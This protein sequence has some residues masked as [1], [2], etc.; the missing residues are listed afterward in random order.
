MKTIRRSF[1][2][3]SAAIL[4]T[5]LAGSLLAVIGIPADPA[6][7]AHPVTGVTLVDTPSD[8]CG[9]VTQPTDPKGNVPLHTQHTV[10]CRTSGAL[11]GTARLHLSI[12]FTMTRGSTARAFTGSGD[13]TYSPTWR[14]QQVSTDLGVTTVSREVQ[15][16]VGCSGDG[17]VQASVTHGSGS[18]AT[19]HTV[20]V[21][22][23]C[24][25]PDVGITS[26]REVDDH[27]LTWFG[28]FDVSPDSA[29]CTA[30]RLSGPPTEMLTSGPVAA[31]DAD[32][33]PPTEERQVFALVADE[34]TGTLRVR[35]TCSADGHDDAVR[36]E[37][38]S[39]GHQTP[40]IISGLSTTGTAEPGATYTDPSGFSTA[41]STATCS[42][43]HR[44]RVGTVSLGSGKQFTAT[45]GVAGPV[46]AAIRCSAPGRRSA[47]TAVGVQFA[48]TSISIE[49]L[50]AAATHEA[51][52]DYTDTF[53]TRPGGATCSGRRT[54]SVG[55]F[56]VSAKT[57]TVTGSAGQTVTGTVTCSFGSLDDA[58][59]N[60]SI[61]FTGR[62]TVAINNDLSATGTGTQGVAYTDTFTTAPGDASCSG[63]ISASDASSGS[64]AVSGKTLTV[65][66][67]TEG[68]IT[69][70]VTCSKQ[71]LTAAQQRVTVTFAGR[72]V[73]IS[74]LSGTVSGPAA[75][76]PYT[77]DFT[78]T[79]AAATCRGSLV[80]ASGT[81]AVS[82]KTLTVTS[83]QAGNVTGDVICTAAGYSEGRFTV[84]VAFGAD[85]N[86][87]VYEPPGFEFLGGKGISDFTSVV[88]GGNRDGATATATSLCYSEGGDSLEPCGAF[89]Y[90]R[91]PTVN[92]ANWNGDCTV[93]R[94]TGPSSI[95][96][97]LH[98]KFRPLD[99]FSNT[100]YQIRYDRTATATAD[101][102]AVFRVTCGSGAAQGRFDVTVYAVA[103]DEPTQVLIFGLVK[104]GTEEA[105]TDYTD[106]FTTFPTGAS[107]SVSGVS[108]GSMSVSGT[109]TKT[110]TASRGTGGDV[111]G[112]ITCSSGTLDDQARSVTVTFTSDDT[113][114][115]FDSRTATV[116]GS[117][118]ISDDIT[119]TPST[120]T[121]SAARTGG[122]LSVAPVVTGTGTTRTVTASS[123]TAG[124]LA[125]RVTCGTATAQATF[126]WANPGGRANSITPADLDRN[127]EPGDRLTANFTVAPNA[128]CT[129]A[130][131][132][133][134]LTG[135]SIAYREATAGD[136]TSGFVFQK[137]LWA[138]SN[139]EGHRTANL[140][141][142]DHTVEVTFSWGAPPPSIG[143]FPGREGIAGDTLHSVYTV[144]PPT[145]C[146]SARTGGTAPAA[147]VTVRDLA[148]VNGGY[149]PYVAVESDAAGTV[150]VTLTCGTDTETA[151]FTFTAAATAQG[152][153]ITSPPGNRTGDAG[154]ALVSFFTVA[155]PVN[156]TAVRSGGDAPAEGVTVAVRAYSNG[157]LSTYVEVTSDG[158][159]D[160]DVTLTCGTADPAEAIFTF[161]AAP[162]EAAVTVT[163][164]ESV[165]AELTGGVGRAVSTYVVSPFSADCTATATGGTLMGRAN[166]PDDDGVQVLRLAYI[167]GVI[168][169][170]VEIVS[171]HAGN[172][173]VGVDCT[174]DGEPDATA[175][176]R[177]TSTG[178]ATAVVSGYD[179]TSHSAP[180]VNGVGRIQATYTVSP[181]ISDCSVT[182]SPPAVNSDA[183]DS[184]DIA[185]L[186]VAGS[187]AEGVQVLR[188]AHI[189]GVIQP[190][191]EV[192][193]R[194]VGGVDVTVTCGG[195]SAT[196]AFVFTAGI[197][198]RTSIS[199]FVSRR[200]RWTPG[201]PNGQITYTVSPYRGDCTTEV[202]GGTLAVLEDHDDD[203]DTPERWVLSAGTYVRQLS[204]I[205]GVIQPYVEVQAAVP[206]T[207]ADPATLTVRVHCGTEHAVATFS[208]EAD[209]GAVSGFV[210]QS[211][212][213]GRTLQAV[214]TTT[215]RELAISCT[216][217][218]ATQDSGDNPVELVDNLTDRN[219]ITTAT[220]TLAQ[221]RAV[222]L[223]NGAYVWHYV[224]VTSDTAGTA[225]VTL[226]CGTATPVEATFTWA[227]PG[228]PEAGDAP[229]LL[230]LVDRVGFLDTAADDNI[231]WLFD[232]FN[233]PDD[234]DCTAETN[235]DLYTLQLHR[236][237]TAFDLLEGP[238]RNAVLLAFLTQD[239]FDQPPEFQN[240]LP[241]DRQANER[242]LI[243]A[244]TRH[245]EAAI[246]VTCGE[247]TRTVRWGARRT[248]GETA[249][250]R[251]VLITACADDAENTDLCLPS[252]HRG[253][254]DPSTGT[255]TLTET[256]TVSPS[257]ATCTFTGGT[258]HTS[259]ETLTPATGAEARTLSV[260]FAIPA[261][262]RF[263]ISCSAEN[264]R[265]AQ[266]EVVITALSGTRTLV[267]PPP[268]PCLAGNVQNLV[269]GALSVRGVPCVVNLVVGV[270]EVVWYSVLP[271]DAACVWT[272]DGSESARMW[273]IPENVRLAYSPSGQARYLRATALALGYWN[274]NGRCTATVIDDL[275]IAGTQ[276]YTVTMMVRAV[277]ATD[278]SIDL[279]SFGGFTGDAHEFSW[280]DAVNRLADCFDPSIDERVRYEAAYRSY[281]SLLRDVGVKF[282]YW[283]WDSFQAALNTLRETDRRPDNGGPLPP[284]YNVADGGDLAVSDIE[285]HYREVSEAQDR[286]LDMT[287]GEGTLSGWV[288]W[289]PIVGGALSQT[290]IISNTFE[291]IKRLP[292]GFACS[293]WRLIVP[294]AS[295]IVNV[296][297]WSLGHRGDGCEDGQ[298][299]I[300]ACDQGGLLTW[301]VEAVNRAADPRLHKG[302]S[303]TTDETEWSCHGP[304]IG[305]IRVVTGYTY[306]D[307]NGDGD[308]DDEGER[309]EI[310]STVGIGSALAWALEVGA[311][312]GSPGDERVS[313]VSLMSGTAGDGSAGV[314]LNANG[315]PARPILNDE[316]MIVEYEVENA[317]GTVHRVK[318]WGR[319]PAADGQA[320]SVLMSDTFGGHWFSTCP[321][322]HADDDH[323]G[324]AGVW[325]RL[326]GLAA[327]SAIMHAL[328][329]LA[330]ALLLYRSVRLL[331]REIGRDSSRG[332][333]TP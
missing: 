50:S 47:D 95:T 148:Y 305:S 212:V 136:E 48:P 137:Y 19:T 294:D 276:T 57:L 124:T 302:P 317:D 307:R 53:T 156:C 242:L 333:G 230:T 93:T 10:N 197:G 233:P 207:P 127:G 182:P 227:P 87:G 2:R 65:T 184:N 296:L 1:A 84:A 238:D 27:P 62:T 18:G 39:F 69:G 327:F 273:S 44:G 34:A 237:A 70:T 110:L 319:V 112:T 310:V 290:Q 141:C 172:I 266:S 200:F 151:T 160:V 321:S 323:S 275:G 118:P 293:T 259:M 29:A 178:T 322:L 162:S 243:A 312:G 318:A 241:S 285:R 43:I 157:I 123:S 122:T 78:T 158:A 199:G 88:V 226:T 66:R 128:S 244:F 280:W 42:I 150:E 224:S 304:D 13:V 271:S 222:T 14:R 59:Q 113:I 279:P 315:T 203:P 73:V 316:G 204:H 32:P 40:V 52:T 101:G 193:S 183:D 330:M 261:S 309:S 106:E 149:H 214:F 131:T 81:F 142:G 30:A 297:T 119:V 143:T 100:R 153:R 252:V 163:A 108:G 21:N 248:A 15:A 51:G 138:R 82:G 94:R 28:M 189:D 201:N 60:V 256:F 117:T 49:N 104:S 216:V 91:N 208:F 206:G 301:P 314:Y 36:V 41:P 71:G 177:F 234:S 38:V 176:V 72:V 20:T 260:T 80:S 134:T 31:D 267:D 111:T 187:L 22:I 326:W 274:F 166:D 263:V 258:I 194:T 83:S 67:A 329:L 35:I 155:P 289:V 196:A 270:Q 130:H 320:T 33:D 115:G 245:V 284:P 236:Q 167:N 246:T 116:S 262:A 76:T 125:V 299:P 85:P 170:Y 90:G 192:V 168:Q 218:N 114:T 135:T 291:F 146:T 185:S 17:S 11:T 205:N 225:E 140:T 3:P 109:A 283:H 223:P 278:A 265:S 254:A 298:G 121:C 55:T 219:A 300:E 175:R 173:T 56:A 133:G 332:G 164:F 328:V 268:S 171:R 210:D 181:Y 147:T 251:S 209:K 74:G 295:D 152:P 144:A 281:T 86:E 288:S 105:G 98:D 313:V 198:G 154:D 145:S 54:G 269:V 229:P 250:T 79:P 215:P 186:F 139:T 6:A 202:T 16:F 331:I 9:A 46:T 132:G 277:A 303:D 195:V 58:T 220:V 239:G 45:R 7:A 191:V 188:L 311:D 324:S 286:Y 174:G 282:G 68:T 77:A 12:T 126:E 247:A 4:A 75:N 5:L 180:L 23:D 292:A 92:D 217:A 96:Y 169:P 235:T 228:T 190:Y 255:V 272:V 99:E 97:R 232:W 102:T 165:S 129:V 231:L 63:A 213:V 287:D 325:G 306:T 161:N 37:S 159:G 249:T 25:L 264:Y 107:C 64:F 257:A 211:G 89:S 8:A 308:A 120:L 253:R 24:D 26:W 221:P 103:I 61:T 240:Y 179:A